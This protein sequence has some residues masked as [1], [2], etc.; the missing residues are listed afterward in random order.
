PSM[1]QRLATAVSAALTGLSLM[2]SRGLPPQDPTAMVLRNGLLVGMLVGPIA[3]AVAAISVATSA[4]QGGLH[5]APKALKPAFSKLNP[6]HGLKR[7]V[8]SQS[9]ID[10]LKMILTVC[11]LGTIA[12]QISKALA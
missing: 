6:A 9:G 8:P 12:F 2:A 4:A 11:V 1:V 5:F 10:L 3:I 7:L